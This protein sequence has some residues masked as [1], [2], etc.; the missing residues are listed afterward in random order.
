MRGRGGQ[1]FSSLQ[2][3]LRRRGAKRRRRSSISTRTC[4][5]P[6]AS[7]AVAEV[8]KGAV[9]EWAVKIIEVR[10]TVCRAERRLFER[11]GR[12]SALPHPGASVCCSISTTVFR[13]PTPGPARIILVAD[14]LSATTYAEVPQD[15][16]A[17][18][19]V[20]DGA[21]NSHAALLWCGASASQR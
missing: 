6:P 2:Q 12:R 1:R 13:G 21:A 18:V 8:D 20:R 3:T 7:R 10:R 19:V 11:A 17:G 4:S 16:L 9:A 14:E 15:R 5:T